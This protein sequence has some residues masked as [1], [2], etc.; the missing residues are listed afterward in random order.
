MRIYAYV[1]TIGRQC[2]HFVFFIIPFEPG[3]IVDIKKSSTCDCGRYEVS[4]YFLA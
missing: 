2:Q 1:S 4:D 3:I